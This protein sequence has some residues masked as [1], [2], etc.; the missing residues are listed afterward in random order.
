MSLNRVLR[1]RKRR[2]CR[3]RRGRLVEALKQ[4]KTSGAHCVYRCKQTIYTL[5]PSDGCQTVPHRIMPLRLRTFGSVYLSRDSENLA[6]AAAQRRLLA[7]LAVVAA[8]GD[9][10]ISRDKLLA[11]LWTEG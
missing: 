11:L 7:I 10:G 8:S 6:G 3:H 9:Q 5:R 2:S 4:A 1:K